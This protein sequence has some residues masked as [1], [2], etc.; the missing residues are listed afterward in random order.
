[1]IAGDKKNPA[2]WYFAVVNPAGIF[3]NINIY[4]YVI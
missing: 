1:M 4:I 3:G 2:S